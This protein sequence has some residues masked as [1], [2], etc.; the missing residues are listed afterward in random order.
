MVLTHSL[1]R[2]LSDEL[3]GSHW[4]YEAEWRVNTMNGL[5]NFDALDAKIHSEK[6][7]IEMG[8]I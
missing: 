6:E 2:C 3:T 1:T 5:A 8:D 7:G 4:N